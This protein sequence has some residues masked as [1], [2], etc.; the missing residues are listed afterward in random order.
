MTSSST[1]VLEATELYSP[2]AG[3]DTTTHSPTDKY[4]AEWNDLKTDLL[5][6]N[7]EKLRQLAFDG[8]LKVSK[9]RSICWSLLLRVLNDGPGDWVNQREKQRTGYLKLKDEFAKNPH[10]G[11]D[12]NDDPLSQSQQSLW[13]QYFG[14]QELLAVIKQDVVRTFPGVDFFRKPLIR[15]TMTNILFNYARE[16]PYMCYRQGM[17]EILAPILFVMHSDHQALQ[18]VQEV[19]KD[20]DP[21]L[22]DVLDPQ[23]LESDCYCI[24]SRV[25]SKIESYYRIVNMVP[26]SQG[27]FPTQSELPSPDTPL[28]PENEVI[29]QLNF[30]R[31]KILAKTDLH[32]HNHLLKLDIPLHIFGIRWLRLL[33][34]RE[35]QLQDLLMLWDAI[36]ADSDTFDL[37]DYILVAMLIRI[38]DK[39]L[40]S[41]YTTCLTHLMRYPNNVDISL[42]LRHALHM[43]IPQKYELPPGAFV[44][45]TSRPDNKTS[46]QLNKNQNAATLPRQSANSK[47]VSKHINQKPQATS[48]SRASSLNSNSIQLSSSSASTDSQ[49]QSKLRDLQYSASSNIEHLPTSG[50]IRENDIRIVD[51][52]RENSPEVLRMEL[53]QAQ[54]ILYVGRLQLKKYAEILRRHIPQSHS[55]EL[56]Q[57]LDGIEELCSFLDVRFSVPDPLRERVDPA[58]EAD[59]AN[60]AKTEHKTLKA[61]VSKTSDP[62]PVPKT[63]N[64]KRIHP[65]ESQSK[66]EFVKS[67]DE[68]SSFEIQI[69]ENGLP[70]KK[71]NVNQHKDSNAELKPLSGVSPEDVPSVSSS[72][73]GTRYEIP[74]NGFMKKSKKILGAR[75]EVE[76]T[77]FRQTNCDDKEG[78]P[79]ADPVGSREN[80]DEDE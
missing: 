30:I 77:L 32:L 68:G 6:N 38:R 8:D 41:D 15:D 22:A 25:M 17:H 10:T 51:G 1:E 26:N 54:K 46:S 13:N 34:G 60:N 24:F 3:A 48:R 80:D 61:A 18:H 44:Y 35:F 78:V 29:G 47:A 74:D 4:R 55:E 12:K 9:F 20:I 45:V 21:I 2:G 58:H 7:L 42:I 40:L 52:Y 73:S 16:H 67:L 56:N 50:E 72:S 33:F 37:P 11:A 36:F 53:Q 64:S 49:L 5:H 70:L 69:G 23:Y 39:L 31:D 59:E 76:L 75:K 57:T 71:S 66:K 63:Q 28:P 19:T 14:D 27:Y 43:K 62:Q 79:T 65:S